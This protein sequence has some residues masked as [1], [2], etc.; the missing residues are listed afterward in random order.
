V[1]LAAPLAADDPRDGFG[2]TDLPYPGTSAT[3]TLSNGDVIAFDGLSVDRYDAAGNLKVNITTFVDFVFPSFL[4]VDPAESFLVLGESTDGFVYFLGLSPSS[5]NPI[6]RL[7]FNYDGAFQD[8]DHVVVSAATL[9]FAN[10]TQLFR[11]NVATGVTTQIAQVDGPSG[12]V[13][14]DA[15]GNLYYGTSSSVFP[16]PAGSASVLRWSAAQVASGVV[17]GASDA[18]AVESGLDG[19][20]G[21]AHDPLWDVLYVAENNFG[22]GVN[23][24]RIVGDPGAPLVEGTNGLTIGN[25]EFL[26]GDG[27]AAF[28]SYQPSSGGTLLYN[29][30]DFFSV[31]ARRALAP[32]RPQ[33]SLTGIGTN[34]AGPFDVLLAGAPPGGI[35]LL[36]YCTL[37]LAPTTEILVPFAFPLFLALD[38]ATAQRIPGGFPIDAAGNASMTFFNPGGLER[39]FALQFLLL[40][41]SGRIAGSSASTTL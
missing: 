10:G 38:P 32:L 14:L 37:A 30:T 40:D 13:E 20:T 8:T 23:R 24:V 15:S 29:T 25:L 2:L 1:A 11:V 36:H 41:A 17:L 28:R 26:P 18:V 21:L 19:A 4:I 35:G 31:Y 33:A 39:T 16:A 12:P 3:A 34:G 27:V 5:A 22:S 9:G 7:T 6:T